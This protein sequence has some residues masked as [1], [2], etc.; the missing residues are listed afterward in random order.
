MRG[1][2][3]SAIVTAALWRIITFDAAERLIQ[4]LRL[5]EA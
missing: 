4:S 1:L 3:K 5:R 2:L